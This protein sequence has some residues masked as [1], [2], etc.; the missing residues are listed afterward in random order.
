M[1]LADAGSLIPFRVTVFLLPHPVL[2]QFL[3]LMSFSQDAETILSPFKSPA[4]LTTLRKCFF[5]L[6]GT[7][8]YIIHKYNPYIYNEKM[9]LFCSSIT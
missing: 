4:I 1:G 7:I 8:I 2:L 9:F 3:L 5:Y 6:Q